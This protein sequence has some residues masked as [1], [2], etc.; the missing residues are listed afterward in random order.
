LMCLKKNMKASILLFCES[1]SSVQISGIICAQVSSFKEQKPWN[2]ILCC[3]CFI[4]ESSKIMK[5]QRLIRFCNTVKFFIARRRYI[6]IV[7][8]KM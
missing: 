2:F 3:T 6:E 5:I 7:K 1:I 8:W 4:K